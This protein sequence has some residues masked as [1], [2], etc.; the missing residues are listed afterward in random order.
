VRARSF[1]FK[2]ISDFTP[3]FHDPV[4]L[5]NRTYRV[6]VLKIILKNRKLN[7]SGSEGHQI[8]LKTQLT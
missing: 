6:W 2:K 3:F 1:S 5:G 8:H 4:R 7:G